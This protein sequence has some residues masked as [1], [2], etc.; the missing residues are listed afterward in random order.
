[1]LLLS[2]KLAK[3][4]VILAIHV[5]ISGFC[6]KSSDEAWKACNKKYNEKCKFLGGDYK[7]CDNPSDM[8]KNKSSSQDALDRAHH[9]AEIEDYESVI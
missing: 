5:L 2:N 8:A 3:T 6:Y 1:M 4:L 9:F 7:V